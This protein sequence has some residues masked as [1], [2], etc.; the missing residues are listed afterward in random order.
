M[1]ARMGARPWLAHTA[2][3]YA[4]M[5]HARNNRSDRERAQALL[6]DALATYRELGMDDFAAA[7]ALAHE[8]RAA[9]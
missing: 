4:R 6:E 2:N 9:T 8:I 3:D 7:T 1:N 5:L